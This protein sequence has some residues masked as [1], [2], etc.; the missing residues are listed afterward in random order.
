MKIADVERYFGVIPSILKARENEG[1]A[2]PVGRPDDG[3]NVVPGFAEDFVRLL[4]IR[5]HQ[6]DFLMAVIAANKNDLRA[7]GRNDATLGSIDDLARGATENRH[8]PKTGL[9]AGGGRA[10]RKH[11][12][13]IGEPTDPVRFPV[14][15]D[16]DG[17][18]FPGAE[19]T[20]KEAGSIRKSEVVA[21]RR[22]RGTVDRIVFRVAGQAALHGP[23]GG[24]GTAARVPPGDG[25]GNEHGN[26]GSYDAPMT[27][28]PGRESACLLSLVERGKEAISPPGDCFDEARVF[29]R[30]AEGVAQ[31]FD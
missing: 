16:G 20:E 7:I 18:S 2:A 19:L 11:M 17:V 21:I 23:E 31:A 15:S 9:L 27:A 3:V 24:G 14:V 26:G 30:V 29:R 22:N 5:L 25:S 13:T 1:D 4:S 12:A 8:T 28:R 6:P 10:S